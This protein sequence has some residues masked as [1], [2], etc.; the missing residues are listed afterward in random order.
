MISWADMDADGMINFEEY[1]KAIKVGCQPD[2]GR[3][4]VAKSI[5]TKN[6]AQRPSGIPVHTYDGGT[7]Y[8]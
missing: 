6:E 8:L 5:D 3:A 1:K 7:I 4:E 2:G